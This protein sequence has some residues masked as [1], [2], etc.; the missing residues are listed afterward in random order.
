MQ[1]EFAMQSLQIM[2]LKTTIVTTAT[3]FA[4]SA[5]MA[6]D[7]T[8]TIASPSGEKVITLAEDPA[9]TISYTPSGMKI[10]FTNI[11]MK[12]VCIE[13]PSETGL[14]RLQAYDGD[15]FNGGGPGL[16]QAP[17]APTAT[18]G[19]GR[20]QLSWTAP[21]DNGGADITGYRIR[22]ASNGS[23]SYSPVVANTGSNA[24][25]Y[26]VTGLTNGTPYQFRV[27]AINSQGV[28]Y[29]S[30]ASNSV[31]PEGTTTTNPGSGDVSTACNSVPSNVTCTFVNGGDLE[32]SGSRYVDIPN[33]KILAIPFGIPSSASAS[34]AIFYFSFYKVD[35][36]ALKTWFSYSAGGNPINTGACSLQAAYAESGINWTRGAGTSGKCPLS[37]TQSIVYLNFSFEN[38]TTGALGAYSRMSV[39]VQ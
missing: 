6:A 38:V 34:G 21:S 15:A 3:F 26:S 35:G 16:P 36:Y 5:V 14:C 24:T 7:K 10:D 13:D 2:S 8:L 33:G 32:S 29:E 9:V 25:S 1:K 18:A 11:N 37:D 20:A 28:G 17:G 31:T 23:T 30:G 4:M 27:S 19:D 22:A 12:V 39:E